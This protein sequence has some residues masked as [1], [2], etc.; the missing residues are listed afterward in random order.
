MADENTTDTENLDQTTDLKDQDQAKDQAT[1][2]PSEEKTAEPNDGD[3]VLGIKTED[4]DKSKE[5]PPNALLGAPE[6]DYE[7]DVAKLPEG[8]KIDADALAIIAPIGKEIGLSNEGMTK[9]AGAYA[10]ILP[11]VVKQISDGIEADAA[12]QTKSWADETKLAVEGGKDAKGAAIKP[13]TDAKG[14]PIY[15]G[16]TMAEVRAIAAKALDNLG[17]PELRQ[18]LETTGLGNH[19]PLVRFAF[20][21]GMAIKE[22]SFERGAGTSGKP[23]TLQS[24]LYGTKE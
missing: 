21:A 12:A 6:G 4:G 17:T 20:K 11:N 7:I 8:T 18:Y 2:S 1:D 15:A 9:L 3:T 5:A 16:K 13:A 14:E 23:A 10:T 22:D 19:E 24:V